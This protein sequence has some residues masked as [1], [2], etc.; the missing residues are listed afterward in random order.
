[1]HYGKT[2]FSVL[3]RNNLLIL[4]YLRGIHIGHNRPW[5]ISC[6]HLGR[7]LYIKCWKNL[8]LYRTHHWTNIESSLIQCQIES[9]S[10]QCCVPAGMIE[11]MN[12]RKE[13]RK[14]M[15]GPGIEPGA[16]GSWVRRA[17]NCPTRPGQFE[18]KPILNNSTLNIFV[19]LEM[20]N[21]YRI[22]RFYY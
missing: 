12:Q 20:F 9:T 19:C 22:V 8:I 13:K 21:L 10:L 5:R 16:S 3:C 11:V 4:R 7:K 17:T 6:S 14:Y 2:L 1:M 18:I 15:A